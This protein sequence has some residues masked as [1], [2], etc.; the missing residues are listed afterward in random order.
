MSIS[1]VLTRVSTIE[2]QLQQLRSG[3]LLDS[4]MGG[5]AAAEAASTGSTSTP[6]AGSSSADFADA[7]AQAEGDGSSAATD[8]SS[9][10]SGGVSA[11]A[12]T[13]T[14][15][16]S[17]AAASDLTTAP[18][19]SATLPT[20]AY[21]QLT[22]GQQQ[23]AST[24][25]AQTGLSPSVV[26]A[27]L[28]AEESG[29]AAQSRQAE[30]NNDWL[31]IGYTDSGTY[32]ATDSVWS[33]PATAA[34]ATAQWLQGQ[35]SIPGYGTASSGVQS[36]LASVGQTPQAQVQAIQDSGWSSSGYPS[37]DSLYAQVTGTGAEL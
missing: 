26:S 33:D 9:L 17:T 34:T 2:Q 22:T 5:S 7:L 23:F 28:L 6:G 35:D 18:T 36:I 30:G 19:G 21:S 8:L 31:N 10:L 15:S 11:S 1:D 32:G 29:S 20:G 13:A 14:P 37:L 12:S 3:A 27:W 25:S 16:D 24:L 4:A